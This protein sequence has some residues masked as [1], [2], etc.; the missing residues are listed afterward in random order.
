M[1]QWVRWAYDH[2]PGFVRAAIDW[3]VGFVV[4]VIGV[5][6]N[7]LYWTG[8]SWSRLW[9]AGYNLT[10]G[11]R[12]FFGNVYLTLKW[13]KDVAIPRAVSAA[14]AALRT[15]V[16]A[17][18][19]AARNVLQAGINAVRDFARGAVNG[20]LS[21]IE[22]VRRWALDQL[23][24][25]LSTVIGL[26]GALAHVLSGPAT[27]AGWLAGAMWT[28]LWRYIDGNL[29]RMVDALWLGRRAILGRVLLLTERVIGRVL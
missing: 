3:V 2:V 22:T 26:R 11:I 5:V 27:L 19:N 10:A 20:A 12:D 6:T 14:T 24:R 18:I 13:L 15:W 16:T 29:E 28:A 8:V 25:L 21:L 17:G 7:A 4:G 9:A 1:D 23:N